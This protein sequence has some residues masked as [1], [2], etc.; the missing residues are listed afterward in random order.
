MWVEYKDSRRKP[1]RLHIV[2]TDIANTIRVY[3]D[4]TEPT[5]L[6]FLIMNSLYKSFERYLFGVKVGLEGLG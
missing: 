5:F 2:R 6:G 3:L 1:R 4:P